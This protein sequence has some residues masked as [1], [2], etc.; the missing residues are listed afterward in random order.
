EN[1]FCERAGRCRCKPGWR[2]ESCEVCVPFPGCLHGR[3]HKAWQC[4][5]EDGWVGSLC[6]RDARPCSSSP[7]AS[8]ATCIHTVE[9]GFLCVCPAGF[10]GEH[11]QNKKQPC[12]ITGGGSPCQNGGSCSDAAGA[13]CLCPPGFSGPECEIGPDGCRPNPCLN[14]GSCGRGGAAFR[15]ACPPGFGGLTCNDTAG[16]SAC[17]GRPCGAGGACVDRLDGTFGCVCQKGFAGPTC[18]PLQHGARGVRPERRAPAP[19]PQHYS[20]PA[21]AFHRLLRPAERDLLKVTLKEA[22]PPGVLLGRAQLLCFAALALLTGLVILGSAAIVFFG[23]CEA[24]LANARYGR[25]VRRHR[26]H[27]LRGGG[28]RDRPDHSVHVILPEKIRLGSFGKRDESV[29]L[30]S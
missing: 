1:G 23:R 29:E 15:C 20:L 27:L 11:C 2:G 10:S 13:S 21:H 17:A 6:D 18:A 4:V 26:D 30:K 14:G 7:C 25:L 19:G 8:N 24:W 3:C 12:G 9:G 22:A 16:R 28:A 5:C